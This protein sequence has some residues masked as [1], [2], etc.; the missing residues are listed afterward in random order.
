MI[1]VKVGDICKYMPTSTVGKVTDVRERDGKTWVLLDFTNLY[2]DSA[3]LSEADISEYR[4]DS[5]KER[6]R[7]RDQKMRS[8]KEFE[9][10]AEEVN[11]D[12]FMPSG[13][14]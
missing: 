12:T 9:E 4:P 1:V 2:Y 6:E 14:G 13:G 10:A 7:G 8:V 5:Y 11:I 3:F